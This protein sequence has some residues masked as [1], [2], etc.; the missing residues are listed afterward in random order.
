M[1]TRILLE[2]RPGAGK[3]TLVRRLA[4]LL[5]TRR[6]VGFT[7]EEIRHGGTRSGFVLETLEGGHRAVLAHVDLPGPPRVGRYG[8]DL[9]VMEQ[10]ALPPLMS[11]A[12]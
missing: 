12:A 2:G 5:R 3:T 8:V 10:F 7:T 9:D 11:A 6:A 4:T 1:P